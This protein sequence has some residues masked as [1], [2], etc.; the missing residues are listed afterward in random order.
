MQLLV[1]YSLIHTIFWFLFILHNFLFPYF[2]TKLSKIWLQDPRKLFCG[3]LGIEGT[4]SWMWIRNTASKHWIN[5]SELEKN[6]T[7]LIASCFWHCYWIRIRVKLS[8]QPLLSLD[9]KK[10]MRIRIHNTGFFPLSR[11]LV[12]HSIWNFFI[13]RE[14]STAE[15]RYEKE[16]WKGKLQVHGCS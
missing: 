6:V 7:R 1:R 10:W 8:I 13:S 2:I 15:R 11:L 5:C 16:R 12:F 3:S 14:T 4:G 9:V